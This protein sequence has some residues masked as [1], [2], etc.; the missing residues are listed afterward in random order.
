[1]AHVVHQKRVR[2]DEWAETFRVEV[3]SWACLRLAYMADEP[4]Q[5]QGPES[6]KGDGN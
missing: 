6:W 3:C 4:D 1:M 2:E 5:P